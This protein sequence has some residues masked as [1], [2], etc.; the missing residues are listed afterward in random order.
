MLGVPET[1]AP[2]RVIPGG[3]SPS[4]L[5]VMVPVPVALNVKEP[6]DVPSVK[7]EGP[8]MASHVG[9]LLALVTSILKD[10]VVIE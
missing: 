7:V 8:V 1:V 9:P 2:D 10:V 6:I 3:R 5:N 4:S